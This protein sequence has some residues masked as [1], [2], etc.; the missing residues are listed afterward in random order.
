MMLLFFSEVND[1]LTP[2]LKEELFV[3]T[4]RGSKLKIN[5]DIIVHSIACDC[6][7]F[8]LITI[9]YNLIMKY[10]VFF[11]IVDRCHRYDWRTTSAY[12]P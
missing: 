11:S 3:D 2:H 5:L 8:N 1:F 12:C 6:K 9:V 10:M 4:S 7:Y